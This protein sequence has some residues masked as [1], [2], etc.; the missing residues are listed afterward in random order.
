MPYVTRHGFGYSVFEHTEDGIASEL[1]VFVAIDAAVKFCLLRVGNA[2]G[3][4]RRI[5]VTGYVEWVLGDARR[6]FG[7]ARGHGDRRPHRRSARAKSVQQRIRRW[8]GFFDVDEPHANGHRRPHGIPR[9]QRHVARSRPRCTAPSLSGKVG[10]ALDPCAAVQVA[11][12]LED[13]Q[14]RE[15]VFRLGAGSGEC[16]GRR[17]AACSDFADRPPRTT[18]WRRCR[19]YWKHAWRGADRNTRSFRSTSWSMAGWSTRRWPAV[20]GRAAASTSRAA[21]MASATSCRT[22]WPCVHAAAWTRPREHLLLCAAASSVEGDVQ[23]WWHPPSGS[24]RAHAF[25]R[26][27]SLA[28]ASDV[29]LCADDR[30][31]GR[32]RRDRVRF[33]DGRRVDAEDDSYYD[34]PRSI[35]E[36]ATCSIEHC[37]RCDSAWAAIRRPWPA[38]DRTA[39]TGTTA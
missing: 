15:V 28:S 39:A 33:L 31:H 20:C 4:A 37:V 27:L 7:D 6:E 38:V 21:P 29:P 8:V 34:L 18:R 19:H 30:R 1:T 10:A 5:S 17:R 2:S 25:L 14:E 12:D 36:S 23:H 11:F 32:A 35:R 13:G 26:R 22:S 9:P 24:G 16:R 3:R